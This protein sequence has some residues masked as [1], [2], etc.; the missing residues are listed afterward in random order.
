M[1][2]LD[3]NNF[4]FRLRK[5]EDRI[6]QLKWQ[7]TASEQEVERLHGLLRSDHLAAGE[8]RH[9]YEFATEA[10][11]LEIKRLEADLV[12]ADGLRILNKATIDNLRHVA[13]ENSWLTTQHC[14]DEHE[15]TQ[16][17]QRINA[18]FVAGQSFTPI[19]LD[20][21]LDLGD[22]TDYPEGS[23]E[24]P[25]RWVLNERDDGTYR[26]EWLK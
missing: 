10:M 21:D 19:P 5:L 12:A 7:L 2:D 20:E 11:R 6:V 25:Y 14:E 15:I 23:A 24:H 26:K 17:K 22:P 3:R 4:T 1:A 9:R 8:V 18:P 13:E 16:L